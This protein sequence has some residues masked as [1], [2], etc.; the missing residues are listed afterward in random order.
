M[1][2]LY[3]SCAVIAAVLSGCCGL[4]LLR[5]G[6]AINGRIA[7]RLQDV[8]RA[9]NAGGALPVTA[10]G[11]KR[12]PVAVLWIYRRLTLAQIKLPSRS[13]LM[14]MVGVVALPVVAAIIVS[15]RNGGAFVVALACAA[16]FYVSNRA[17]RNRRRF[18]EHLPAF[19]ERL[20]QLLGAGNSL[21]MAFDKA[22]EYSDWIVLAYLRP[23]SVRLTLGA[24]F[25]ESLNLQGYRLRIPQLTLLSI[26]AHANARFGGSLGEVLSRVATMMI[27]RSRVQKE[28]DAMTAEM[29]ISAKIL[30]CLPI[31][32]SV[33]VL[34]TNRPYMIFFLEDPLGHTLALAALGMVLLG[35]VVL[36]FIC[37][38][39]P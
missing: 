20:H 33:F 14:V 25:A 17:S 38:I 31:A 34:I 4:W 7:Q 24:T 16:L 39:E 5:D 3:V 35:G 36:H 1:S 18:L 23:V 29:R 30:V 8:S 15:P 27:N 9:S 10:S 2:H 28:F 19:I 22:L 21:P 12:Y 11:T 6:S 32:V 37:R 26:V 13:V